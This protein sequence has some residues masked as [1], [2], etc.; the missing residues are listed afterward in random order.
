[1]DGRQVRRRQDG[2]GPLNKIPT[3]AAYD[4]YADG[5]GVTTVMETM[6][7]ATWWHTYALP[8]LDPHNWRNMPRMPAGPVTTVLL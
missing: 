4:V 5:L 6:D 8:A 1:V 3:W 2:H 7:E